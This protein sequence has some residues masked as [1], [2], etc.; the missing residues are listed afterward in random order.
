MRLIH[1]EIN[2]N[3]FFIWLSLDGWQKCD[4][5]HEHAHESL[6]FSN[7]SKRWGAGRNT[8]RR[9]W[10]LLC[11]NCKTL[12]AKCILSFKSALI[13]THSAEGDDKF[14]KQVIIFKGVKFQHLITWFFS[15]Q[16]TRH[17]ICIWFIPFTFVNKATYFEIN[18]HLNQFKI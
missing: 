1:G 15:K 6:T 13:L 2:G 9:G 14:K 16:H 3:N 18:F 7:I 17:F 8:K 11:L 10:S 12:I 5:V 4:I